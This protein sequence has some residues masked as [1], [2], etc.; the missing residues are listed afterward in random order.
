MKSCMV[1][2]HFFR[3]KTLNDFFGKLYINQI[4]KMNILIYN[5]G[6]GLGDSIQIFN[7]INSLNM[8]FQNDKLWYLSAHKNHFQHSLSE[9]NLNIETFNL[10]L[11]Y[12]GFRW[13]HWFQV[14]NKQ[15]NDLNIKFDLIIDLQSKLGNTLIL[16][17]L[18]SK[19]FY[20]PTLNFLLSTK[21][22]NYVNTKNNIDDI[23]L[24]LEKI[25][26]TKIKPAVAKDGGDI[27]FKEFN[28]K[29]VV[30]FLNKRKKGSDFTQSVDI[31]VDVLNGKKEPV[32]DMPNYNQRF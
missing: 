2:K 30:D 15:K 21:Q 28:K 19:I 22:K 9:Y 13:K 4:F 24:N 31:L 7:L 27:K 6:G 8:K 25:L 3:L 5:S 23:L 1:G 12:F 29:E 10:G 18:K 20:S 17:R 14:K 16:K 26:D 11:E 32:I